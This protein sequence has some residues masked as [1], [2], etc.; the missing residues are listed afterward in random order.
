MSIPILSAEE[1]RR[2]LSIRDLTDPAQGPHAMQLLIAAVADALVTSSGS[3]L[4]LRRSS[5]VVSVRDNYDRLGYPREAV[6]RDARYTRYV[7]DGAVLRTQTSAMLPPLLSELSRTPLDDALLLCPG[8]V[9]RRDCID[10]LHC[11][12]P[13]QVDVWRLRRGQALG[14]A[15]LLDMVEIVIDAV[16]PGADHRTLPARHPY[17][18]RGLQIEVRSGAS[19][20]E[21]GEC[22][23]LSPALLAEAGHDPGQIS[24]LALGLGL[25]RLLMLRKAVPDIRLLRCSDARVA[26]QMLD[27]ERYRPVSQKPALRRDLSLVVDR[28]LEAEEIGDRVRRALGARASAI[29]SVTVLHDVEYEKLPPA[30]IERLGIA[31]GQRNLL[32]RIVLCEL[33][34]TLTSEEANRLRDGVYAAL[35]RGTRAEWANAAPAQGAAALSPSSR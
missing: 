15:Q 3:K 26:A 24:G 18:L 17:T 7:C 16:L 27:L 19:W 35:H 30:A 23:L 12:E 32:L 11:G 14:T 25:D 22:G 20:V 33:E 10:R 31:P 9:Y 4:V 13:H 1:L 29:E 2:A 28:A 5:P 34:R 21:V 6:A 8:I